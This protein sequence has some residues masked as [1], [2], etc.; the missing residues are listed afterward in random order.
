MNSAEQYPTIKNRMIRPLQNT[1]KSVYF[2]AGYW[3]ESFKLELFGGPF[4]FTKKFELESFR[5][6]AGPKINR[7]RRILKG[8]NLSN[9]DGR[10]L[11]QLEFKNSRIQEFMVEKRYKQYP[12]CQAC[13]TEAIDKTKSNNLNSPGVLSTLM[14]P[15]RPPLLKKTL[16]Y[17]WGVS[18]CL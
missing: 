7:F 16:G 3:S 8:S 13:F 14:I 17:M 5:A 1:S 15:A 2:G 4:Q 12:N 10:L 9:F 6:I 11:V 18:P